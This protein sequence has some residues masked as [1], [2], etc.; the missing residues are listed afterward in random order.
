MREQQRERGRRRGGTT[1]IKTRPA[2]GR[3]GAGVRGR[4][5]AGADLVPLVLAELGLRRVVATRPHHGP[6]VLV[7]HLA[8][9]PGV[10]G[11]TVSFRPIYSAK[12]IDTE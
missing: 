8:C 6:E 5:G 7:A 11:Q 2:R 3:R 10:W 4:G 9:A 12:R 1:K